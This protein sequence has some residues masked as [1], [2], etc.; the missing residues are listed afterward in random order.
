MTEKSRQAIAIFDSG[1][2]GLTVMKQIIHQLPKESIIYFGDTARLPYG[3]KSRETIIRYSLENAIFLMEQKIK[4]MVVACN[5]VCSV[6]F[7]KLQ[8]IFNIPVIG[9]IEP[10]VEKVVQVT[11]NQRVAILGTKGTVNSGVYQREIK[12]KLPKAYVTAISCPL[13]VPLVEERFIHHPA[14]RL[15]VKEYLAPLKTQNIDTLLLGCTHY[16]LLSQLIQ[17]EMGEGI[18]IIDSASTCAERVSQLLD[19]EKLH[20]DQSTS[21]HQF[22]VSDDPEKFRLLGSEFLG[23]RIDKVELN[24]S[25]A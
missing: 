11:K 6:A 8:Q 3:E 7:D 12:K 2:G 14:A 1:V 24:Y 9:V 20:S 19:N 18:S 4:V 25:K 16:P 10:G 15:I 23:R 22:F 5:T 17:E 13:F 21:Q